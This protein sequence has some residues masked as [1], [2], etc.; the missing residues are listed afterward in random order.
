MF[1]GEQLIMPLDAQPL[2]NSLSSSSSSGSEIA[3]TWR[4]AQEPEVVE[5]AA[6]RP[7][8]AVELFFFFGG[9]GGGGVWG[10]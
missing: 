10:V 1:T 5:T 4:E 2:I 9:G 6:A 8:P 7:P 3:I